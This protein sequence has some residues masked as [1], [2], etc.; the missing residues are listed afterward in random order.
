MEIAG[1]FESTRHNLSKEEIEEKSAQ[2]LVKLIHCQDAATREEIYRWIEE[3]P[4]HAVAF[5]EAEAAWDAAERL[6]ARCIETAESAA[7]PDMPEDNAALPRQPAI[8]PVRDN[9]RRAEV[10]ARRRSADRPD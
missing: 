10:R 3:R 9:D 4:A 1:L 7:A 6:K 2:L 5:A 8:R